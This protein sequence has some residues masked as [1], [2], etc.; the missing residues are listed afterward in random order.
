MIKDHRKLSLQDLAN[1]GNDVDLEVNW[2]SSVK[3]C[4]SIRVHMGGKEAVISRDHLWS[5][6]LLM[7]KD[8]QQEGMLPVI[9][10]PVSHYET[11]VS[12]MAKKN[13]RKGETMNFP[14]SVSINKRTGQMSIK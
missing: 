6:I 7:S 9:H 3:D 12:V 13:V 2:N 11:V 8:E 4:K 14:L 1:R 10:V 5:L